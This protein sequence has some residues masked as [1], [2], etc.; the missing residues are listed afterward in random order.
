ML[1]EELRTGETNGHIQ[2]SKNK[3]HLH[4]VGVLFLSKDKRTDHGKMDGD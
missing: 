3:A 1:P 4:N 2:Q